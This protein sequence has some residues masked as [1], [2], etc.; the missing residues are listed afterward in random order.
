MQ[1]YLD[2]DP[3]PDTLLRF[4]ALALPGASDAVAER[5]LAAGA[6]QKLRACRVANEVQRQA[7]RRPPVS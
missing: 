6:D 5:L 7:V 1:S 2:C 4:V 3:L